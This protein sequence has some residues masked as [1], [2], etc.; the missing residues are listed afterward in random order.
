MAGGTSGS[1]AS[2][3]TWVTGPAHPRSAI[4]KELRIPP[5]PKRQTDTT[6][7]QFLHAQAATMLAADFFHVD[8][9]VTL[10]RLY[11]L[12]ATEAGSAYVHSPGVTAHPDGPRATHQIRTLLIDHGHRAADIRFLARDRAGQFTEPSD[13]VLAGAGIDAVQIPPRSP[14]ANAH[15]RTV[16][17]H[18]PDGGHRPDADL[19]PTTPAAGPSRVRGPATP[20]L[21]NVIAYWL[22]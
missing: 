9:A 12:F 3:S 6:W 5:V 10:R 8:C 7:R 16:R 18:R 1:R 4:L 21:N 14:R 20:L 22:L 19:R 2:S 17:A 15:A 11:C 13:A